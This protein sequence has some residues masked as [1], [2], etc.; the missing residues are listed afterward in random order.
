[1]Q[2]VKRS[3]AVAILPASPSGGTPGYFA[4]PDPQGGVPATIPGYEFFNNIQEE[5]MAVIEGQG[6][7]ASDTDRTQLR[8]AIAK[9]IQAGQR[10]VI[11]GGAT[12]A[13]AVTGTGK[14]VYWDS[15]NSRFDLALADGSTKQNCVGFA[16]VAN[17]N[18][19]AFGDAV[20]FAG[21]T[22]GARYYLDGSTAGAIT[23]SAP[24]SN[25]VFVGIA[26]NATEIFVDIDAQPAAAG[27]QIQS[28]SASVAGNAL[29]LGLNP[30][31]LDFRANT[32]TSGSINTRVIAAALSLVVPSGATL[33]AVSGQSARLALIAID[34]AGT[35]EL[36]VTNLAG[37]VNLDETTLIY[38]TAISAAASSAG[39]VY[40]TTARTNVPFRIVGFFDISET[41]AGTWSAAPT[42]IQGQGGQAFSALQSLGFGQT[43]QSV[44]RN[45]GTNY[46]NTTGKPITLNSLVTSGA[47]A[48]GSLSISIAGAA[49]FVYAYAQAGTYTGTGCVVIP[50]GCSYVIT[51]VGTVTAR[52]HTELR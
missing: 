20:L 7:V 1:M 13:P 35:V 26:R 29:T 4:R 18:V 48:G 51:E 10:S 5:L 34:N 8:Q 6:L 50:A 37:G 43:S 36:A 41:T 44:T 45:S 49:A 52:A 14:A 11:I 25:S 22:P 47:G 40:S 3:T 31:S 17:G 24:A 9:M 2:R 16:D 33:G 38:T 15:V 28:I 30:T 39:V 32:L 12:F 42:L 19:Y 21:L 27:K 46:Y 23:T